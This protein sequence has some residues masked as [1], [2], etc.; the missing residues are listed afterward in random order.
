M[1]PAFIVCLCRAGFEADLVAELDAFGVAAG[2]VRLQ[3]ER[4]QAWVRI[5][6]K[7]QDL[8]VYWRAWEQRGDW[9]RFPWFAREVVPCFARIDEL[10]R[11]GRVEALIA[12]S[13]HAGFNWS[14]VDVLVPDHPQLRPLEP[15][16]RALGGHLARAPRNAPAVSPGHAGSGLRV[17]LSSSTSAWLGAHAGPLAAP[18]AAGVPRLKLAREAPSRSALKLEE[19]L[20][21][22]LSEGERRRW[23]APGFHAVD[24]G[25]AP[26]GWTWHLVQRGGRVIAID[27][28]PMDATLMRT[29]KVEHRRTDGFRFVPQRP[30]DWLV[31]DMVEQPLRIAK[32][33]AEWLDQGWAKR[34]VVNFKLPMKQRQAQLQQCLA[35]LS[36][37]EVR[38]KQLYHDR[39][40]VTAVIL[41]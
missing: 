8:S 26:G 41:P 30:A 12:A 22:L 15:L 40:E 7:Q 17:V 27:N 24:L 34:A 28:G 36:P 21:L 20:L 2:N 31:C 18:V 6:G 3:F 10:P 23:L 33:V 29:G 9:R 5:T 39:E 14:S 11:H 35:L 19:A 16:A 38:C 37:A 4:G 32:R 13:E 25:A 1:T